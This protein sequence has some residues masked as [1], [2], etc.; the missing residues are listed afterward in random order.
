MPC[1]LK[2]CYL[3]NSQPAHAR[4][5]LILNFLYVAPC[6]LPSSVSISARLVP[7]VILSK[8][9]EC[10]RNTLFPSTYGVLYVYKELTKNSKLYRINAVRMCTVHM[11]K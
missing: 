4:S 8:M 1:S 5:F 3:D 7:K 2:G 11:L 9:T 10:G 6:N